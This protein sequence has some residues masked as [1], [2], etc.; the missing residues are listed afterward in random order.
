[1]AASYELSKRDG[2]I[3]GPERPLSIAGAT[4]YAQYWSRTIG[5]LLL[6]SRQNK[7]ITVAEIS[8]ASHILADDVVGALIAMGLGGGD[9]QLQEKEKGKGR[10]KDGSVVVD[11]VSVRKWLLEQGIDMEREVIDIEAFVDRSDE[12]FESDEDE[13]EELE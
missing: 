4:S 9:E 12:P 10:R 2:R 11:K 1:M 7:P 6:K 3:G 13:G 5:Q 8:A